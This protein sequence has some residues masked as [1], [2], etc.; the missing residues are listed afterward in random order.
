MK[1]IGILCLSFVFLMQMYC[2]YAEAE[3]EYP[4]GGMQILE[5]FDSGVQDDAF[6]IGKA[7]KLEYDKE[8][9]TIDLVSGF[10]GITVNNSTTENTAFHYASEGP[11]AVLYVEYDIKFDDLVSSGAEVDINLGTTDT[12]QGVAA[13]TLKFSGA[14]KDITCINKAGGTYRSAKEKIGDFEDGRWYHVRD[15]ITVTTADGSFSPKH[16]VSINGVECFTSLAFQST[17]YYKFPRINK[18]Y[19]IKYAATSKL[20]TTFYIDN[21]MA[22]KTNV[23][24]TTAPED[25]GEFLTAV[26]DAE[27]ILKAATVGTNVGE[28][29]EEVYQQLLEALN[30][31][32]KEYESSDKTVAGLKSY[33]RSMEDALAAFV[34]IKEAV[35]VKTPTIQYTYQGATTPIINFADG[36]I[37]KIPIEIS[38]YA[39]SDGENIAA[40]V[41]LCGECDEDGDESV[42]GLF[43]SGNLVMQP[44]E[45]KEVTVTVDLSQYAGKLNVLK[46][47]SFKVMV[48]D[49]FQS[50]KPH[51]IPA[52]VL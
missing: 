51:L 44:S 39:A 13:T 52:V 47:L 2:G 11:N 19:A 21:F 28:Y 16:T 29:E 12:T 32:K 26:R 46:K 30:N 31:A 37:V 35:T 10:E 42:L 48:W 4:A 15:V 22:Y 18:L 1:K 34:P 38:K 50:G 33:I 3:N 49:G 17:N 8:K 27:R 24:T 25:F 43:T 41:L 14:D 9:Y 23:N 36:A 20:G 40:I 6:K 45:N 7:M 5:T